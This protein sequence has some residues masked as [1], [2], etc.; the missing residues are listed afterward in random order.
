[1]TTPFPPPQ[2]RR[3]LEWNYCEDFIDHPL[4]PSSKEEGA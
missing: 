1:M 3:G 2:K 4:S